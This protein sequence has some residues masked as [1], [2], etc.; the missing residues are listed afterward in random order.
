MCAGVVL[1]Y[2]NLMLDQAFAEAYEYFLYM[3]PDLTAV[4]AG[5]LDQ[6]RRECTDELHNFWMKGKTLR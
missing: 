2:F 5:W 6:L 3:E 4:R 1:M